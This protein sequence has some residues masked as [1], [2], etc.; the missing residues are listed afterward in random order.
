[1]RYWN[2]DLARIVT[3]AYFV[4]SDTLLSLIGE[5]LG[6]E[7]EKIWSILRKKGGGKNSGM[8]FISKL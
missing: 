5:S 3:F 6:E 2:T 1:M 7:F 8:K 4:N